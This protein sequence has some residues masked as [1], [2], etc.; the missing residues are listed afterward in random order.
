MQ[1]HLPAFLIFCLEEGQDNLPRG[2]KPTEIKAKL[3]QQQNKTQIK[4]CC[5][6]YVNQD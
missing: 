2:P 4:P 6:L 1:Y 3:M 5:N